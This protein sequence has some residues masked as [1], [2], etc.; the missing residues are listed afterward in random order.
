MTVRVWELTSV[1][2][3][4]LITVMQI[5]IKNGYNTS[6]NF[7]KIDV[8]FWL[9]SD[10]NIQVNE[11]FDIIQPDLTGP[12]SEQGQLETSCSDPCTVKF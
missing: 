4:C 9:K 12:C 3:I 8:D 10:G 7:A 5:L 2:Y 6:K 11:T 1:I